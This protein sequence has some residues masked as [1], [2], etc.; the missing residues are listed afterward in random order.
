MTALDKTC[1][2]DLAPP[3]PRPPSAA[4]APA[5]AGASDLATMVALARLIADGRRVTTRVPME[6]LIRALAQT[7]VKLADDHAVPEPR[8]MAP[9]VTSRRG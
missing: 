3:E 6:V 7:V 2:T 9:L 5:L 1:P 4:A 8:E